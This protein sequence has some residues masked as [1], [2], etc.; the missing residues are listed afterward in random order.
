M[1]KTMNISLTPELEQFIQ[2]KVQGGMYSSSSE[3][4]RESLRLMHSYDHMHQQRVAELSQAINVGIEQL[5]QKKY[6]DGQV[7][8]TNMKQKIEQIAKDK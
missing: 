8:R 1:N 2:Q 7:S 4:I 5:E 6:I 3:V